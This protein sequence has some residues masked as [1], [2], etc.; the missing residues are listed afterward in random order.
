MALMKC[1]G[2]IECMRHY[3]KAYV[4]IYKSIYFAFILTHPLFIYINQILRCTQDDK[5]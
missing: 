5:K 1:G 2:A 4:G 3:T